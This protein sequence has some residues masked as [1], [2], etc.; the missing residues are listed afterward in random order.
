MVWDP[1]HEQLFRHCY[2]GRR[3]C[4]T[5]GAGFIGGHLVEALIALGAEVSVI[6]DLSN[7]DA[8]HIGQMIDATP[9][10]AKRLRFV[11]GSIL[12]PSALSEAMRGA[13]IV[14]HLAAM[15]S[16]PRSIK[17]PQRCMAVNL[18][19][20]LRVSEAARDV[21]ASRWV[22]SAS[23][24][25]YG[26]DPTLPKVETQLP[27]PMSPYAA[28]KLAA[29]Y[30]VRAWAVSYGLPGV[31][32]RYF[33]VFG[34]RQSADSAYAAVIAAFIKRMM[35]GEAPVIFGDGQQ[36]RDFT[37]VKNAVYAN[38]LAGST[39]RELKGEV[40]NVGCGTRTTLLEIAQKL[41][42]VMGAAGVVPIHQPPRDGDVRDSQAD[43]TRAGEVLGYRPVMGL[44]EGLAETV[45]WFEQQAAR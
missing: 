18:T 43:L 16:V 37:P 20:S 10:N 24:S 29:E 6:D 30:V 8:E 35:A 9:R 7:S 22:Y 26:D 12:D 45:A 42:K 41:A 31:S 14:F 1:Q 17:E 38:L 28:S 2:G 5:G 4:V 40:V 21:G 44:D 25:A 33:N 15:G 23:S 11:H 39:R 36:S 3:V 34:P 32:L 19:G 27:R 13:E